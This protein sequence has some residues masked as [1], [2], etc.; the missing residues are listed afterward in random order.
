M[1]SK[2]KYVW[3]NRKKIWEGIWNSWFPNLY[4]EKIAKERS[5]I[6]QSNVCGV[7]DKYGTFEATFIKNSSACGGCGCSERY[8]TRSLSSWCYLKDIGKEPLWDAVMTEK[9]EDEF[10]QKTGIENN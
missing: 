9:E 8:K 5:K 4:V 7:Y 2:I 1:L 3:K 10:R 6:C